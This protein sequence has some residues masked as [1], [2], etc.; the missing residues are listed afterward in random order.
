MTVFWF[1]LYAQK[2]RPGGEPYRFCTLQNQ[3][4]AARRPQSWP[5]ISFT[6]FSSQKSRPPP[7]GDHNLGLIFLLPTFHHRK[8]G[9]RRVGALTKPCTRL[10]PAEGEMKLWHNL[11]HQSLRHGCAVP[12]PF[13]QGRLSPPGDR[14]LGQNSFSAFSPQKRPHSSTFTAC[15]RQNEYSTAS[16]T[17]RP[18]CRRTMAAYS[19]SCRAYRPVSSCGAATRSVL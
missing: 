19:F 12:P 1:L 18:N 5:N 4:P 9:P 7:L 3:C 14:Q 13:A 10:R 15:P 16:V 2:E 8:V 11:C 6:Y 17:G